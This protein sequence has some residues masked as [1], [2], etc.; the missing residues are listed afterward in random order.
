MGGQA[1]IPTAGSVP[2]K[3]HPLGAC[4]AHEAG[5]LQRGGLLTLLPLLLLKNTAR[6]YGFLVQHLQL[7]RVPA[8]TFILAS[9]SWLKL[10]Y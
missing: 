10:Q 5:V 8:A 4:L 1:G 3:Q 6:H 2:K 9:G 7:I